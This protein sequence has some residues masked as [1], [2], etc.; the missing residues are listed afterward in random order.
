MP[1]ITLTDDQF[2][3]L[4]AAAGSVIVRD[5]AGNPL[6]VLDATE[7]A[8]VRRWQERRASGGPQPDLLPAT[9]ANDSLTALQ[10]EWAR[11]GGLT[12]DQA[13]AFVRQLR[14]RSGT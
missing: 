14:E 7:A 4:S 11:T 1:E 13:I 3:V 12:K 10:A 2:R 6:G 9:T 5:P 8:I